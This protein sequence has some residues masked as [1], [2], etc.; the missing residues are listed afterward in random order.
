MATRLLTEKAKDRI[1][2]GVIRVGGIFVI[3]VVAAIV[4][5]ISLEALPLF[6]PASAGPV[7][8]VVHDVKALA[9]GSHPR[10]ETR[11]IVREDGS[12]GFFSDDGR[13]SL[14]DIDLEVGPLVAVDHEIHGLI[15]A[16][17][18]SGRLS[19]GRVRFRDDWTDG[20]RTTSASWRPAADPLI[21]DSSVSWAG[22]TANSDGEGGVTAVAVSLIHI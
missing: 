5:N 1:A 4:V 13:G 17:D 7:E 3:L 18:A 11:W 15:S 20:E 8:V 22:V 2:T 6:G 10:R 16:I 19:V 9:V 21:L 14:D 12:I